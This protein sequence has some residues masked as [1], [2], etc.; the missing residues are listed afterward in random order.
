MNLYE[1]DLSKNKI[2]EFKGL[3][4]PYLENLWIHD[5]PLP[6]EAIDEINKKYFKDIY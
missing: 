6:K 5:N 4:N 1:L 3:D 2:S